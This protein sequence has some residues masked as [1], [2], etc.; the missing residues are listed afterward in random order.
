[1]PLAKLQPAMLF[2]GPN[3]PLRL[4]YAKEAGS[5]SAL[6]LPDRTG[7]GAAAINVTNRQ[8]LFIAPLLDSKKSVCLKINTLAWP[9]H[10]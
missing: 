5:A 10:A 1:M 8:P 4:D 2:F 6:Q 7:K 9:S 3:H